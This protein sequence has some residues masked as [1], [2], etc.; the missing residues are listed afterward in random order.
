MPDRE[1]MLSAQASERLDA[2]TGLDFGNMTKSLVTVLWNPVW[3]ATNYLIWVNRNPIG[4]P[5]YNTDRTREVLEIEPGTAYTV[6]VV[7]W[8][9]GYTQSLPAILSFYNQEALGDITG[10]AYSDLSESSVTLSWDSLENAEQYILS[11]GTRVIYRGIETSFTDETI[12]PGGGYLYTLVATAIGYYQS[13]D[14]LLSV[15]NYDRLP[16]PAL[17]LAA[18]STSSVTINITPFDTDGI[19]HLLKN[20]AEVST[21]AADQGPWRVTDNQ[22]A[23]G[24]LYL[25]EAYEDGVSGY[26]QS[27]RASLQVRLTDF[28]AVQRQQD[29][30]RSLKRPFVK[31]CRLR[32][33]NPNNTTAFA[34][35]NNRK[36]KRGRAFIADGSVTANLQ[37]G[38]RVSATVTLENTDGAYNFD[39]NKI[40]FGQRVAIDEGLV[41]S[42]G[43][44]Y[45]RQ[46]GVFVIDNP[47]EDIQPGRNTVTYTLLDKWADLDGTLGGNLEDTYEAPVGTNIFNPIDNLLDE[48][49]GNGNKEDNVAPVFTEYYND[50]TQTLSDGSV[51]SMVLSPYT[52]TEDGDGGTRGSVILGL[53]GMVNAWVGYDNTGRLRID[54][55]QDDILDAQKAVLYRF[56]PEEV[57]L[58]GLAYTVKKEEVFNDYI[59]VGEQ[60]DDY[61]QPG[62]RAEN[63]DPKSDTNIQTIGRKTKRESASGFATETQCRDLAEWRLKRSGILQRAVSVSCSQMFHIELNSLVEIVR[64]DKPGSPIERH[65]VQGYTRPLSSNGPMTITAVSTADYPEATVSTWPEPEEES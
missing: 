21:R 55:S 8:A 16:T 59:V 25:Y 34:L 10:F 9:E 28:T 51:V 64:T 23:P 26:Y 3:R 33:L 13:P 15:T 5:D 43:E 2:P 18:Q 44:E 45:W 30:L 41:L 39:I 48:D 40:W 20:G 17:M 1:T 27:L 36:N 46:T 56:S 58:L 65:L 4:E 49:R 57:T 22:L 50:K 42:N 61:S 62:G 14:A 19:I 47:R 52:L 24:T 11:K 60:L 12:H 38:Q 35:D 32:F 29:Y 7:A 37:N 63:Y 31:L 53:A 6:Y 54:P